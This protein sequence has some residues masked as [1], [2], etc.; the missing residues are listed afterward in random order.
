MANSLNLLCPSCGG[1]NSPNAKNCQY[2][3]NYL[4]NLTAWERRETPSGANDKTRDYKYFHSLSRL[5][6]GSLIFGLVLMLGTYVFFFDALSEDELVA[7]S[8]VWFLLIIFGAGGFYGEKAIHIILDGEAKD[9][10]DGLLKA[11]ASIGIIPRMFLFLI[12][13]LPGLFGVYK[14]L[15]SPVLISLT[16]TVFWA[17]AL[18]IFLFGIFPSL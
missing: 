17:A 6:Y 9:F 15:S 5:Y 7:W 10:T 16:V 8:P 11:S 4:P 12:F 18:Y 2:C 1:S 14:F 13:L 3:G